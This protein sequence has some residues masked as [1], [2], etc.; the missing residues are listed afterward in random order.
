MYLFERY[1]YDNIQ[2]RGMQLGTNKPVKGIPDSFVAHCDGKFTLIMYGTVQAQTFKKVEEDILKCLDVNQTGISPEYIK[3][4][5]CCYTSTN[6]SPGEH[7]KLRE[8]FSNVKLIGIG[9]LVTD[10]CLKYQYIAKNMLGIALDTDQ[11]LPISEFIRRHYESPISTELSR[12]LIGRDEDLGLV[13]S[14][15][16]TFDVV[17]IKG[18]S[19]IG[20]TNFALKIVET[21]AKK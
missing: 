4:I 12:N 17:L 1:S 13:L 11:I 9:E 16:N 2:P 14:Q 3:E 21:F 8:L 18:Q 20:K 6:L 7:S 19:G 15:L 10:L 5:I